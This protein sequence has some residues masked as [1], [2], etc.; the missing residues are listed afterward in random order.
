MKLNE[1][2]SI[3]E[4]QRWYFDQNACQP[5]LYDALTRAYELGRLEGVKLGIEA[6]ANKIDFTFNPYQNLQCAK[7]IRDLDPVQIINQV[8]G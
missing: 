2:H 1:C 6:A 3:Q 8:K 5:A 4:I 7:L